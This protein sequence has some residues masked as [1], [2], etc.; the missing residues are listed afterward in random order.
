[1]T[2]KNKKY[3]LPKNRILFPMILYSAFLI[4]ALFVVSL[5]SELFTTYTTSLKTSAETERVLIWAER[6]N[7]ADPA[8][9]QQILDE[10]YQELSEI[11]EKEAEK[12]EEYRIPVNEQLESDVIKFI[13]VIEKALNTIRPENEDDN[14]ISNPAEIIVFDSDRKILYQYPEGGEITAKF[15]QEADSGP[16]SIHV[17]GE[18]VLLD[19][20]TRAELEEKLGVRCVIIGTSGEDLV[21]AVN[22]PDHREDPVHGPY[23]LKE[24]N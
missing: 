10:I 18:E 3:Q 21:N 9:D 24:E 14:S 13:N 8:D 12:L 7:S 1:M 17:A 19:D 11:R 23:E 4:L 20:I 15:M 16:I 2:K 5:S 22:D 6:Y